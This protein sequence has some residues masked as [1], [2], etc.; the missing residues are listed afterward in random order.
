MIVAQ[1]LFH[2]MGDTGY[3]YHYGDDNSL[4]VLYLAIVWAFI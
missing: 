1:M 4:D 2:S 3:L